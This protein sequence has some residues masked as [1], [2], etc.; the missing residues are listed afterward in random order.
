[1]P[2]LGAFLLSQIT[3]RDS[4]S[5]HGIGIIGSKRDFPFDTLEFP[6]SGSLGLF[7]STEG[8]ITLR[9]EAR[10]SVVRIEQLCRTLEMGDCIFMTAKPC[11]GSPKTVPHV[12]GIGLQAKGFFMRCESFVQAPELRQRPSLGRVSL[13]QS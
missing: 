8:S 11:A 10:R 1:R 2:F 5:H 4:T 9:Q 13:S 7:I 3:Q 12:V 6:T